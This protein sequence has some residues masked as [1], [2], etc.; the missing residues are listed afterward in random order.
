MRF[1]IG[2]DKSTVPPTLR[3]DGCSI[4]WQ[5]IQSFEPAARKVIRSALSRMPNGSK[6]VAYTMKGAG[7]PQTK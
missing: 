7:I 4:A 5:A 3:I 1:S 2:V 6:L